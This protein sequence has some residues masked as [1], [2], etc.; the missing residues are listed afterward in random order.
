MTIAALLGVDGATVKKKPEEVERQ[1]K[2]MMMPGLQQQFNQ[3]NLNLQ[4][5]NLFGDQTGLG[6][7]GQQ[8]VNSFQNNPLLN[9]QAQ[10]SNQQMQQA[11]LMNGGGNMNLQMQGL[12]NNQ[13][14]MNLQAQQALLGNQQL[15]GQ[16][17]LNSG[18][19]FQGQGGLMN[20]QGMMNFQGGG[21]GSGM[22]SQLRYNQ[23]L[24]NA[25]MAQ[26]MYHK[27]RLYT[28]GLMNNLHNLKLTTMSDPSMMQSGYGMGNQLNP[29]L[30]AQLQLQNGGMNTGLNGMTGLNGLNG[31][32]GMNGLNGMNGLGMQS[33]GQMGLMNQQLGLGQN[34]MGLNGMG[35]NGLGQSGLG[36]NG[37]GQ[38][39][40]GMNGMGLNGYNRVNQNYPS[41]LSRTTPTGSD[42]VVNN[43]I[44]R[45][46]TSSN[47]AM[48][49]M[50]GRQNDGDSVDYGS[51]FDEL[52]KGALVNARKPKEEI[53]KDDVAADYDEKN[54]VV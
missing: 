27:L 39:G 37:L 14:N 16:G 24:L 22:S 25:L 21:L 28:P 29:Q 18:M 8:Q 13:P 9:L 42:L 1:G 47:L 20:N 34:G 19:N 11:M 33:Y 53:K 40:L 50:S 35:L 52:S 17:L 26:Q 46:P 3:P 15:M 2:Q 41:M 43:V 51:V 23:A 54:E 31:M 10:L 45:L 36:L 48:M 49:S 5:G 6:G 44:N 4:Q 7:L 30:L 32:A 12:M 38:N